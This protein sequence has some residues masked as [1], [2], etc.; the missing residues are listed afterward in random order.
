FRPRVWP[1]GRLSRRSRYGLSTPGTLET[2]AA[3][4][5]AAPALAARRCVAVA[6]GG[7]V[8][9]ALVATAVYRLHVAGTAAGLACRQC[10]C[11]LPVGC[12]GRHG[13][14]LAVGRRRGRR[15]DVSVSSRLCLA[16]S[17]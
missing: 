14:V 2:A 3:T 1:G 4:T 8:A 16:G 13:A 12:F 9:A 6:G 10:R 7:A 11:R 5:A 17:A 15:P